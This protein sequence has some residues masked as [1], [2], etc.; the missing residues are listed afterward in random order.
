ML[1][2]FSHRNRIQSVLRVANRSPGANRHRANLCLLR[3]RYQRGSGFDGRVWSLFL[4]AGGRI[5]ATDELRKLGIVCGRCSN[6]RVAIH[7]HS[8]LDPEI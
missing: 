8:E 4:P 3:A 6:S 7:I 1:W 2:L 5:D